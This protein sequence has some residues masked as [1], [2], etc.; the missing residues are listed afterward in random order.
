MNL[1][2]RRLMIGDI[3]KEQRK[4]LNMTQKELAEG[5][6]STKY[7]Y[8]IE[9]NERNPSAFVLN[10]LSE[11]LGIELFEY[12]N[13]FD[14]K[15]NQLVLEHQKN[16][17]YYTE[18]SDIIALKKESIKAAELKDFQEEPLI[19]DIKTIHLTYK[20]NVE[21]KIEESIKELN[22]IVT[23]EDIVAGNIAIINCYVVLSTAYQYI[24]EWDKAEVAVEKAYEMI[25]GK[26]RYQR[27]GTTIISV[28][29]SLV[30]VYFNQG[31]Y[32]QVIE[33]AYE[34][35]MIHDKYSR[36][37]RVY[38]VNFYL[39]FAYFNKDNKKKARK[40]FMD[41]VH[42]VLLFKNAIDIQHILNLERIEELADTLEVDRKYL[43]E[44]QKIIDTAK[45]N[46]KK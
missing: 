32:D 28:Y 13:Y 8:L 18:N 24:G 30:A 39:A 23:K 19:Y 34:L 33:R 31:D 29:I 15:N 25:K 21:G 46:S 4:L 37:N 1:G 40:Y 11:R 44:F 3:I 38:Y 7:I 41:G 17:D 45:K 36:Y 27:Y 42:S 10:D 26:I 43:L 35:K 12:Y 6:C 2:K 5:I 20:L 16:F 22:E 9:K 14:Y